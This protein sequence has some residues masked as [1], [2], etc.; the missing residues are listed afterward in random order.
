MRPRE[1]ASAFAT[2]SALACASAFALACVS[3]SAPASC[4]VEQFASGVPALETEEQSGSVRFT[5]AKE[6]LTLRFRASLSDLPELWPNDSMVISE[7]PF[8]LSFRYEREPFGADGETE[9]PRLSVAV[10]ERAGEG[11]TAQTTSYPG[12][13]PLRLAPSLFKDCA[14]GSR[15]CQTS[16]T[17]IIQRMDG[18]PFPPIAVNWRASARAQVN[19]CKA[20]GTDPELTLE[21]AEP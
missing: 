8:E 3:C 12:P 14:F 2:A 10:P 16:L 21:L 18:A 9:M 20:L 7:L 13:T 4:D 6:S 11:F 15:H 19:A 1:L 5:T 17:V